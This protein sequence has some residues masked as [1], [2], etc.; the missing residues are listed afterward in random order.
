MGELVHC[1]LFAVY[2]QHNGGVSGAPHKR[3]QDRRHEKNVPTSGEFTLLPLT[4]AVSFTC[5][6]NF[7]M[8]AN[9]CFCGCTTITRF[10]PNS[11]TDYFFWLVYYTLF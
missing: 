2:S 5:V 6:G 11:L 3:E 10:V 4:L 9:E 8:Y 1:V 7:Y